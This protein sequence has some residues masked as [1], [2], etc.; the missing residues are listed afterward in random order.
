MSPRDVS[1]ALTVRN[2][3]LFEC[4]NQCA[5]CSLWLSAYLEGELDDERF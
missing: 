3:V 5:G 4:P 2:A 1:G